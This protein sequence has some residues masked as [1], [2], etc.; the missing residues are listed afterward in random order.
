ATVASPVISK[1]P[2]IRPSSSSSVQPKPAQRVIKPS[3]PTRRT[4]KHG[5]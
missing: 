1:T 5:E 3:R 2:D 4:R